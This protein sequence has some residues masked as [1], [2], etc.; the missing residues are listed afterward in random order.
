M[1]VTSIYLFPRRLIPLHISPI[2]KTNDVPPM[3]YSHSF[4]GRGSVRN[5]LPPKLT[6]SIWP[7]RIMI[8]TLSIPKAWLASLKIEWLVPN[9]LALNRFQ[10]CKHHKYG[11]KDCQMMCVH[12]TWEIFEVD[13]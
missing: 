6:M 12:S 10:N 7:T 3:I 5:T 9:T 4:K 2:H 13:Q 11:E 1:F 8:A